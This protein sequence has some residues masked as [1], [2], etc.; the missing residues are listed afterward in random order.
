MTVTLSSNFLLLWIVIHIYLGSKSG[1]NDLSAL[2]VIG[3]KNQGPLSWK[4]VFHLEVNV[5]WRITLLIDCWNHQLLVCRVKSP[6]ISLFN[7]L[8]NLSPGPGHKM[9]WQI[10]GRKEVKNVKIYPIRHPSLPRV[11]WGQVP[12]QGCTEVGFPGFW[13]TGWIWTELQPIW[14][15]E[16]D[17]WESLWIIQTCS[18]RQWS[19][20]ERE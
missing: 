12:C 2:T 10:N 16:N 17:I 8:P 19:C 13:S 15:I 11:T 14:Y 4:L 20:C 5:A 7:G 6:W 18:G 9:P 1:L 3:R